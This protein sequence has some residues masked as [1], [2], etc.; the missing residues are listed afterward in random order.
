MRNLFT[1]I[2]A[3]SFFT[4]AACAPRGEAEKSGPWSLVPAQSSIS[5]VTI[6]NGS[7]G[8]VNTFRQISGSVSE[9]G[10]AVF[11]VNLDS[12]DTYN[13]IRD[14]RMREILFKTDRFP[15]ARATSNLT[16]AQISNLA[17]GQTK[18]VPIELTVDL[19]GVSEA[20]DIEMNVTRIGVNKVRVD[21]KAP[22]LID[23]EDFGFED[24]LA[25]LQELAG[26]E[27]ISPAVSVNVA[28][29]FER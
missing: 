14:P 8:E 9:G 15:A 22:L 17:V 5:Y 13:E 4:L 1:I 16:M 25:K 26:L 2:L 10:Q 6:K 29:T 24:G 21:N 23:A 19:H 11:T 28:L 27:S 3:L 18:T 12:V 7:L 20:F